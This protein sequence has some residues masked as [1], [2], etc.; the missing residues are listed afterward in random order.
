[1]ATPKFILIVRSQKHGSASVTCKLN[2]T[3][4]EVNL[5]HKHIVQQKCL[6]LLLL[7]LL[8]FKTRHV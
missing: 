1:L 6:L 2:L 3:S 8:L 5:H 7:L 4:D